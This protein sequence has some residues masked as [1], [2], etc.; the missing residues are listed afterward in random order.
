[1]MIDDK[2]VIRALRHAALIPPDRACKPEIGDLVVESSRFDPDPTMLGIFETVEDD[3]RG[4]QYGKIHYV[5][6]LSGEL[7][8]WINASMLTLAVKSDPFIERIRQAEA[9]K[10]A[11]ADMNQGTATPV[12]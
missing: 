6:S 5:R 3:P 7:Q 1:M 4:E 10:A 9:P 12:S 2:M 8:R 11:S